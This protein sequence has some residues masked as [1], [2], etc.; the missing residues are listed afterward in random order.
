MGLDGVLGMAPE[1]PEAAVE[2]GPAPPADA[3]QKKAEEAAE[4]EPPAKL[5]KAERAEKKEEEQKI[6]QEKQRL[7]N[8]KQLLIEKGVKA[9]D[10]L[11]KWL[12]KLLHEPRFNAVPQKERKA[13]FDAIAKRID[14]ERKKIAAEKKR[15]GR[16]VFKELLEKATSL[17]MLKE[18][19]A[20][21]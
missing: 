13:L 2:E 1:E 5:T 14:A 6:S 17:E 20:A 7:I 15:G 9:F 16:E 10:K 4:A 3:E 19:S 12:P 11:D 18:D 8:F 21:L